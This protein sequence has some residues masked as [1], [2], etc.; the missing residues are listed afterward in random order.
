M[1][2]ALSD[3]TS[4]LATFG[5]FL[6]VG[7]LELFW[8]NQALSSPSSRRWFGNVALYLI[9]GGMML[10]PATVAFTAALVAHA[11]PTCVRAPPIGRCLGPLHPRVGCAVLCEPSAR[12]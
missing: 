1:P 12:A 2:E 5:V 3:E 7:A 4:A 11:M 8:P 9:G 6:A 10:L